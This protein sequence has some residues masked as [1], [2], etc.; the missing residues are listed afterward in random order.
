MTSFWSIFIF[1]IGVIFGSFLNVVGLRLPLGRDFVKARS[2]CPVCE[3][4]LTWYELIPILS[5]LIQKGKCRLCHALISP[6]YPSMELLS[7]LLFLFAYMKIGW[8]P[9]IFIVSLLI[10]LSIIV[11]VSDLRYMI[12]PNKLLL[13]FLPLFLLVR[14]IQP[15][16]PWHD[17][18]LGAVCGFVLIG[19]TIFLSKGGMGVGDLKLLT[20]L[21]FILGFKQILVAFTLAVCF[22]AVIGA[23]LLLMKKVSR[24]TR[25]PFAP[26][27]IFGALTSYFYGMDIFT[28]YAA[29]IRMNIYL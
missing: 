20:L 1:I 27:L 15:L 6:V 29:L 10:S 12:I 18:I 14:V 19:G 5:F 26:Y 21:G 13:F 2:T 4:P 24:K 8:R 22:G 7:G 28:W 23:G 3:H 25:M 11:I 9:E 17:S 16:E